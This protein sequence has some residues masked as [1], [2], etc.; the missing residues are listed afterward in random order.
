MGG[1]QSLSVA[2]MAGQIDIHLSDKP[3]LD[4]EPLAEVDI[5]DAIEIA[6]TG[7]FQHRAMFNVA[8]VWVTVACVVT[9]EPFFVRG[10]P[11]LTELQQG[12]V[13]AARITGMIAGNILIGFAAD[14]YG[15]VSAITWSVSLMAGFSLLGGLEE[16]GYNFLI[17]TR[18]GVG[19]MGA[20]CI[21]TTNT[22][23]AEICPAETRG[24][25]S[26]LM[27]IFWPIGLLIAVQ[28]IQE[29]S[30]REWRMLMMMSGAPGMLLAPLIACTMYE[31][32]RYHLLKGRKAEAT[33][34]I[35]AMCALNSADTDQLPPNWTLKD[36]PS[37]GSG[38][39]GWCAVFGSN[40]LC[41]VTVPLWICFFSI[42]FAGKG[43]IMWLPKYMN[44][45][46]FSH[47]DAHDAYTAIGVA[48]VMSIVLATFFI[49]KGQ[50]RR[51]LA[52]SFLF[53]ALALSAAVW[54]DGH[55]ISHN[56]MF[57]LFIC[58]MF[59]EELIWCCLYTIVGEAYPS[60]IRNTA[61]GLALGPN[62]VGGV[63]SAS[64]GGYL[65]T[66]E[67]VEGLPF[68]PRAYPF[69]ACA[70]FFLVG[71]L[72]AFMIRVDKTRQTL[73]DHVA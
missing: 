1:F 61:S 31:S 39:F 27:H 4:Q 11:D 55:Y 30:E 58:T 29:F 56:I 32:P 21:M 3:L 71:C 49:D 36:I 37:S 38:W 14:S 45:M 51:T 26:V 50:R 6:G 8:L 67:P 70:G 48:Q 9:A 13:M 19:A 53:A 24:R 43:I 12:F 63:I 5:N 23:I 54:S 62:R 47:S 46:G 22:Y 2:A 10:I 17:F 16:A 7:P 33:D 42:N 52:I 15:R 25:M 57:W 20:G 44:Q 18:F 68:P 34:T 69:M 59:F 73:D 40:L 60:V 64:L 66:M 72:G 35:K 41:P 28:F 65:M